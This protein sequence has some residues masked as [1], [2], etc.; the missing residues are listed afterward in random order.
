MALSDLGNQR[1]SGLAA[2]WA[3]SMDITAVGDSAER[4]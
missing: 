3:A 2:M 1:A 4:D